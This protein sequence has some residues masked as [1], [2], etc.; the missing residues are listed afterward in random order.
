MET[1][2]RSRAYRRNLRVGLLAERIA[3][4][5]VTPSIIAEEALAFL[6]FTEGLGLSAFVLETWKGDA[7]GTALGLRLISGLNQRVSTIV[8]AVTG[9]GTV[10]VEP[11]DMVF[12]VHH[13]ALFAADRPVI[14]HPDP[15]ES[16]ATVADH[17]G[18][19]RCAE[20]DGGKNGCNGPKGFTSDRE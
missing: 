2:P 12:F 10:L 8:T 15:F 9:I 19:R 14:A 13:E 20:E 4:T 5:L 6:S 18:E 17:L 11:I 1:T 16:I 7:I 3:L